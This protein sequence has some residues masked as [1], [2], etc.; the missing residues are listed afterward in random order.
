MAKPFVVS[1]VM[2]IRVIWSAIARDWRVL[3]KKVRGL[4]RA[5]AS[6]RGPIREITLE[7]FERIV[8]K[9]PSVPQGE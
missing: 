3:A 9:L 5:L 4:N 6:Q 1:D 2:A 8:G 7:L